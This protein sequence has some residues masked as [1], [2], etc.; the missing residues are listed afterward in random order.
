MRTSVLLGLIGIGALD[1]KADRSGSDT[2][3]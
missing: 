1:I 2:S 3:I